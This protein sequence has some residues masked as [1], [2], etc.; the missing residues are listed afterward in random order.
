M[1]QTIS[2]ITPSFNQGRFLEDAIRSV[3]AQEGDFSLDYI[4][5]DGGST[6]ESVE[7]ISRYDALLRKGKWPVRCRQLRYR[8]VSEK[9]RGQSAAIN[10][11]FRMAEGGVV[12]W[13]NSDDYYAAGACAAA[14]RAF[15]DDDSL[16]MIYGD[17]YIVDRDGR[18]QN[19]YAAEPFFDLWKLIHLYD[20]ILQPSV[21]M[22]RDSLEKAG[23]LD[24][25]LQYIMDWELWIRLS[26]FGRVRHTPERLSC[27]RV[28]AETKTQ[29]AGIERWR[30]IRRCARR[31]GQM[32]V[33]PVV[34][35]QAFHRPLHVLS[36]NSGGARSSLFS[37]LTGQL[38]KLYYPLIRNNRSGIYGDGYAERVAFLSVPVREEAVKLSVT[39]GAVVPTRVNY[40]VNNGTP[41]AVRL[42][43]E[44]AR[45]EIDL[46]E[47]REGLGF[48]HLRF[49]SDKTGE[50]GPLP[51]ASH[52]R[53]VSF[54]I[55]EVSLW[56][57]DG[58]KI[59]D[60]GLPEFRSLQLQA[61]STS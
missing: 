49:D 5:C 55:E 29:S 47:E 34:V 24:K 31:Y 50:V 7:V 18:E 9:D 42:N 17:G 36:G 15:R 27:A 41:R 56:S 21:F 48:L 11:G 16:A 13:L 14:L 1:H 8:W 52:K 43:E 22:R 51:P 4:I 28:Y 30:E 2:I 10:K 60:M 25:D 61:K 23:F 32:K 26:R 12:A 44:G 35:T 53:S 40:S 58:K 39:L 54:M 57:G 37:S 3:I 46:S 20:F 33:P 38:R 59:T 6:D 45:I 19:V